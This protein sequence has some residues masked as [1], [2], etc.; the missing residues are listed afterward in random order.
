[1]INKLRIFNYDILKH[2][3]PIH[4]Y[5]DSLLKEDINN[6]FSK[7]RVLEN[8]DKIEEILGKGYSTCG[9]GKHY[10]TNLRNID[11]LLNYISQII[12]KEFYANIRGKKILYHRI[13]MN[14]IY[15]NC[16]GKCHTHEGYNDGT[17][18]FYFNVPKNGSKLIILKENI[19][20]VVTEEHKDISNYIEVKSGDLIIHPKNLPH[21]VSKH[22]S[23]DPRVC[24]IFDFGITNNFNYT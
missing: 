7:K 2:K 12:L 4:L 19:Q 16:S 15:K 3:V 13:W 20:S 8:G 22:M 11:P 24:F 23:N 14:K 1:M 6:T 9:L 17:A 21:A 18:I 5:N 10:V